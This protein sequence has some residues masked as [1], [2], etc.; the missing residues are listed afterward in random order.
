MRKKWGNGEMKVF[1]KKRRRKI[2]RKR[3]AD[4]R[5]EEIKEY[6]TKNNMV[7]LD[8]TLPCILNITL[9]RYGILKTINCSVA[10]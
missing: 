9:Q 5:R 10:H 7:F 4:E 3:E 2:G 8:S 1:G 6:S